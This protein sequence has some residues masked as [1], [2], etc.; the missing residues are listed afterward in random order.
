MS[1]VQAAPTTLP[2]IELPTT[3]VSS[4]KAPRL[5]SLDVFR[6][7]TI[8]AMVLV[9]NP[10]KG[11]SYAPLEHATWHGWTPTDLIFPFFLFIVGVATPFS[12][13]KRVSSGTETRSALLTHIWAR[14]L[15]LFML[16]ELL[17]G[18]PYT[19]F[20]P[21]PP[22]FDWIGSLRIAVAV[23]SVIGIVLLLIPWRSRRIQLLMPITLFVLFYAL[24]FALHLIITHTSG[25]PE[26]FSF[27]NGLLNPAHLRIP[28]VLQRIGICY[29][30][31]ATIGLYFGWP[32][33][34]VSAVL[35]MTIYSALMFKAP[36]PG[37]ITGS[38]EQKDN[39][40][41][42]IDQWLLIREGRWNHAYRPYPDN[43]G[44][45]STLPAIATVLIGIL[46][47]VWL[48][49]FRPTA[50][51]NAGLLVLG[52]VTLLC[53]MALDRW[54][55]PIN[56]NLWTPSFTIFTA[57]MA[58]LCLGAVFYVVDVLNHRAWAL[59]FKIYGMNAIAAFVVSG[60]LYKLAAFMTVQSGA[61]RVSLWTWC[62]EHVAAAVA[63]VPDIGSEHN[64]SLAFAL[65]YVLVI[66][67]LMSILYVSRV[68]V[69]V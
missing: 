19:S 35:L 25:L 10:G 59:P 66:L 31:A 23:F 41:R 18:L 58:M 46:A 57:G 65:L 34:L 26:R 2:Q 39:L 30:V 28:G 68:F 69:K 22:G 40:A 62:R 64:Q 54:L 8:A 5:V 50:E 36:F 29:G 16:G 32:M 67:L 1:T 27:G 55:M 37:H 33:V 4:V 7:I 56:K 63:A 21:L 52:L 47:G 20:T 3:S 13:A 24:A 38:L 61:E 44:A 43:E 15:S 11:E 14:A 48:R 53:G 42:S 49:T 6:G 60:M 17:T 9:N 45:L 51:R 12:M